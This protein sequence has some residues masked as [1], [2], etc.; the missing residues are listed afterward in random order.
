MRY[1]ILININDLLYVIICNYNNIIFTVNVFTLE[2]PCCTKYCLVVQSLKKEKLR[3]EI[4]MQERVFKSLSI[5][6][7]LLKFK[8]VERT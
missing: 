3:P 5:S 7:E 6:L 4:F 2:I 1:Y 8:S